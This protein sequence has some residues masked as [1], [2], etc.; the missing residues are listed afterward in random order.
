MKDGEDP[1]EGGTE[2]LVKVVISLWIPNM[3]SVE[4]AGGLNKGCERKRGLQV[5]KL[6]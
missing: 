5:R 3:K 1:G 4:L 6:R 2:G